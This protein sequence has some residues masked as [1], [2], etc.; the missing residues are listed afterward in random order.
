[1]G[2]RGRVMEHLSHTTPP[3][4]EGRPFLSSTR[5]FGTVSRGDPVISSLQGEARAAAGLTEET[6]SLRVEADP[7]VEAPHVKV[8]AEIDNPLTLDLAA[9]KQLGKIHGE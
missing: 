6:W 4:G 2:P 8:A 7:F 5:D 3:P 1:M 9:L